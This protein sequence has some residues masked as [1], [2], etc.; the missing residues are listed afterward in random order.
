MVLNDALARMHAGLPEHTQ[1]VSHLLPVE[2][3]EP[4]DVSNAVAWRCSEQGKY[5]TGVALPA[6]AGY[7]AR[8]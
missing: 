5:L 6:D 7:Q 4:E 2:M 3:L 8:A 1:A